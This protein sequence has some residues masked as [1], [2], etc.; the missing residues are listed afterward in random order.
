MDLLIPE[1]KWNRYG[2]H[3]YFCTEG[4]NKINQIKPE[5]VIKIKSER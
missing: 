4:Y 3:F 5:K 2:Y 1:R